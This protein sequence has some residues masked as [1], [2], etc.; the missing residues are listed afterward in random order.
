MC[1]LLTSA[2]SAR[3]KKTVYFDCQFSRKAALYVIEYTQTCL[4]AKIVKKFY[5]YARIDLG[6]T[7]IQALIS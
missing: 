5:H 3:L 1:G 6:F 2:L 4:E 7:F